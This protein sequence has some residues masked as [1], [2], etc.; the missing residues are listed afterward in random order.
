MTKPSRLKLNLQYFA[1][2]EPVEPTEQIPSEPVEP[3]EP[4]EPH[5]EPNE[6]VEPDSF[7]EIQYN[8]EQL[9]L[10]KDRAKELAQKGMNYDKAVERAKQEGIDTYIANQGY[11]WNG[12]PIKT[13]AEYKQALQE[14]EL[15]EKY[16]D[17]PEEVQN[18]LIESKKFREDYTRQQEESQAQAKQQEDYKLF[19]ETF[20]DTEPKD[21]PQTVWDE[22]N[23]GRSLV[24]AF[25]RHENK[26]LK[27]QL[28]TL[29]EKKEIEQKNAENAE[30]ST[31]S[32]TGQGNVNVDH[33]T[34]DT[35]EKNRSDSN[36]VKKNFNKIMESRQK[37]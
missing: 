10:D 17:L 27:E 22:V 2:G 7:L 9:K 15:R 12:K 1:E 3:T 14:Q 13:E 32:V 16:S 35:F 8:K 21:I 31:G 29:T 18:E 36:W 5:A 26:S 30:S 33:I 4:V 25:T 37:W 19:L 34:E 11:E 24:D 23:K 28:K 6:P 20:P